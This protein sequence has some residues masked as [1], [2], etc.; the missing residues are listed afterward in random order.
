MKRDK[1]GNADYNIKDMT[2]YSVILHVLCDDAAI[3]PLISH[4]F[5]R[6]LASKHLIYCKVSV[7]C[8]HLRGVL[9]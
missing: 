2:E 6:L 3:S 7:F 1:P 5:T 4:T 8:S 9:V